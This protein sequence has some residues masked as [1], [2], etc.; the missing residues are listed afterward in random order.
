MEGTI[1][2]GVATYEPSIGNDENALKLPVPYIQKIKGAI[3]NY[4]NL[5]EPFVESLY[6]APA[7][8]YSKVTVRDVDQTGNPL[9]KRGYSVNE[10]YTAK[11]FPV[12]VTALKID[13]F[14]YTQ[15]SSFGSV[16]SNSIDKVCLSQGY[17]I[18]LNDM[19]GKPKAVHSFNEA[20]A[21]I[22]STVYY[23]STDAQERNLDNTVTV[24]DKNGAASTRI[25]GRDIEYFSDFREQESVNSGTAV[26][27]GG[28]LIPFFFPPVLPIPHFPTGSNNDYRLFRSA[29][30]LKVIQTYGIMEKVVKT[31]D[32]SSITTENEAYDIIT[33]EP[34]I[35]RTN[36]EYKNNIYTTSMPAYW[37]Y[38]GM[39]GAYS[40]ANAV[41]QKLSVDANGG[42]LNT[43][44]NLAWLNIGDELL[45]ITGDGTTGRYWVIEDQA[46][47]GTSSRRLITSTG[48]LAT[49]FT[50]RK[51]KVIRS[52][53]RN[54]LSAST[55]SYSSLND[56]LSGNLLNARSSADLTGLGVLSASSSTFNNSWPTYVI[57]D[58]VTNT[59]YKNHGPYTDEQFKIRPALSHVAHGADGTYYVD[60]LLTVTSGFFKARLDKVGIWANITHYVGNPIGFTAK[61]YAPESKLYYVGYSADDTFNIYFDDDPANKSLP[62]PVAVAGNEHRYWLIKAMYFSKGEH[63]IYAS[64][65]NMPGAAAETDN[66]GSIG[67]EVYDNTLAGLQSL[68]ANGT[69]SPNYIFSTADLR[70]IPPSSQPDLPPAYLTYNINTFITSGGTVYNNYLKRSYFNPFTS[71]ILGNWHPYQSKVFLQK[72]HIQ[73]LQV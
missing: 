67:L 38:P 19:H 28:D 11:D 55:A 43:N 56:P 60:Q 4:F 32:G 8:G 48:A 22:A 1:S 23:F 58:N 50:D 24:L 15:A 62:D 57:C 71:G 16:S 73:N 36:N 2:S 27:I 54:M 6:P 69:G 12:K 61:F 59:D 53:L 39:G 51:L 72:G 64:T 31:Q 33:G 17:S 29:C 9:T 5:E 65:I 26:N 7:I 52:G 47:P 30:T 70:S 45:D 18:E 66:P 41:F 63:T 10:F 37:A 35:T 25:I 21:E 42:V 49:A 14:P 13:N 3:N 34:I 44:G 68:P 46:A 40:N 20:G